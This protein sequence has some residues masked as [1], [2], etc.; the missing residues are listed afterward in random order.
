MS[1]G[2]VP[3]RA[4]GLAGSTIKSRYR[5]TTIASVSHDVVVYAAEEIR[6]GR[7]VAV[8][9]LRD[10][11]AADAEFATAVFEQASALA[12]SPHVHRGLPRV[13]DCGRT[14]SGE[15]FI[16]LEPT[17]GPTLRDVL[18][19]RGPL[20]PSTALRIASQVG[21]AIETLHHSGIVHGEL[22]PD[23]LLLI[24]DETGTERISLVDVELTGAY[25]T[26]AGVRRRRASDSTSR[27]PEQIDGGEITEATDQYGLGLLLQAM[28]TTGWSRDAGSDGATPPLPPDI[29]RIV[30]TALQTEPARR[31]PDISVM[32]ND[33]WAAQTALPDPTPR[34]RRAETRARVHVRR[35]RARR[36]H[37]PLKIAA[38]V[39][40]AGLIAA[41]VWFALS[42]ALTSR[43]RAVVPAPPVSTPPAA[44]APPVE[45]SE[46]VTVPAAVPAAAV[47]DTTTPRES[48][49]IKKA[50]TS[51]AFAQ[52]S[53]APRPVPLVEPTPEPSATKPESSATNSGDGTAIVDWVLNRRR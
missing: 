29:A 20:D 12:L 25:R 4:F 35:A 2:A 17:K 6:Y 45:P 23:A 44:T 22:S 16:A 13:Y 50:S 5:L 39:A 24:K 52:P 11:V 49:P 38:A 8:K 30:A 7:P 36:P 32:I 47:S 15:L 31:F 21:E 19:A 40:T 27:A 42:G 41:V 51:E 28:V 34:P 48:L 46:R 3:E 9:V 14:E 18:D 26:A 43:I 33:L 53:A 10:E 1:I 37:V